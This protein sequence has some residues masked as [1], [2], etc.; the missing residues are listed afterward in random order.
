MVIL[1][2]ILFVL[3]LL[4]GGERGAKSFMVLIMN[5]FVAGLSIIFMGHGAHAI[6][7]MIISCV[8]FCLTT[9]IFQN[10]YNVKT[11]S[12]IIAI[13]IL[14]TGLS[15]IVVFICSG[16]HITGFNEIEIYE[17][18]NEYISSAV[19][20]SMLQILIVSMIWGQLGAI[21]DTS[22]SIASAMN[23]VNV[24]NSNLTAGELF[25]SGMS[26]GKSILGTTIN[27]L[28]FVAV[29]ESIMLTVVYISY[30]Y[31]IEK[32]LNSKS[33][34]QELSVI[35]IS[36]IGCTLI[37]PLTAWIFSHLIKNEQIVNYFHNREENEQS[38]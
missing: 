10:G 26:V 23:E 21:M 34:F 31:T 38:E 27:T 37:I 29:G 30:H 7:I 19:N 25:S 16:A 9:M 24:N 33:F 11:L 14:L 6:V 20:V 32:I 1:F 17:E 5:I 12:S 13:G 28:V 22:M 3:M 8:F 4:I 36:C 2:G 15:I 35:M 18:N